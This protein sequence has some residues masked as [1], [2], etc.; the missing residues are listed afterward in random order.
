MNSSFS[1][2]PSKKWCS[3]P[4]HGR[5]AG[6]GSAPAQSGTR[7]HTR[8]RC[9]PIVNNTDR[10]DLKGKNRRL[11]SNSAPPLPPLP[12]SGTHSHTMD[13]CTAIKYTCRQIRSKRKGIWIWILYSVYGSKTDPDSKQLWSRAIFGGLRL[14]AAPDVKGICV[15]HFLS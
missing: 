10:L 9:T 14:P 13:R 8:D 6:G 12:Q 3:P 1:S 5:S 15:F 7:P 4:R 11:T 2:I